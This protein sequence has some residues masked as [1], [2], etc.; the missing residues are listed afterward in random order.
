MVSMNKELCN[1]ETKK[2]CDSFYKEAFLNRKDY[3]QMLE[4]ENTQLKE[5]WDKLE[6][7][8]REVDLLHFNKN[9][10][11]EKIEELKGSGTK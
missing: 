5:N 7:W 11:L 2:K 10:L 9:I 4:K 6:E 8:I 1:S 3:I